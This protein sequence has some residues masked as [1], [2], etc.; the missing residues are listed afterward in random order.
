MSSSFDFHGLNPSKSVRSENWLFN[1]SAYAAS[2][3]SCRFHRAGYGT[4]YC[5]VS[6]GRSLLCHNWSTRVPALLV[7]GP[8]LYRNFA[9]TLFQGVILARRFSLDPGAGPGLI[10]IFQAEA[11]LLLNLQMVVP[12]SG[13]EDDKSWT[14]LNIWQPFPWSSASS[15]LCSYNSLRGANGSATS[16]QLM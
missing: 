15:V 9:Q 3:V 5:L 10:D 13:A 4:H 12:D 2:D 11:R 7:F 16:R 1:F 8:E 14:S 6:W